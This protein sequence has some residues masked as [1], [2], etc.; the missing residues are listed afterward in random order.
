MLNNEEELY[1]NEFDADDGEFLA[2]DDNLDEE[3]LEMLNE[4]SEHHGL[5]QDEF[6][7]EE[8][9]DDNENL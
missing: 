5:V 7:D 6:D 4:T 2:D 1:F 3:L 9:D 8:D